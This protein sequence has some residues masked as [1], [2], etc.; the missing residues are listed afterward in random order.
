MLDK[1]GHG[2]KFRKNKFPKLLYFANNIRGKKPCTILK[3]IQCRIYR[4][5]WW[6]VL[7]SY[8]LQHIK[9]T[10]FGTSVKEASVLTGLCAATVIS[11]D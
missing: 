2:H 8:N 6:F 11:G 4:K 10:N 1:S 5:S 3:C 9:N 7:L